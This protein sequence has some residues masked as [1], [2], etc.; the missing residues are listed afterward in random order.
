MIRFKK[1][2]GMKDVC[3]RNYFWREWHEGAKYRFEF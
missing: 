2:K 1:I 3:M